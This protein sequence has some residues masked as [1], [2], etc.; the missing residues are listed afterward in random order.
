MTPQTLSKSFPSLATLF[1]RSL[2]KGE[3]RLPSSTIVDRL[4]ERL[5]FWSSPEI[6]PF[7]DW[8]LSTD[9]PYILLDAVFDRLLHFTGLRRLH[10]H[11]VHFTQTKVDIL[12]HL[13]ILTELD[14]FLGSVAP[15]NPI[16]SLPQ[17]L[18][19]SDFAVFYPRSTQ[20]ENIPWIPL[21][22]PEN[23]HSLRADLSPRLLGAAVEAIPSFTNVHTLEIPLPASGQNLSILAKFPA[24]RVLKVNAKKNGPSVGSHPRAPPTFPLLREYTGPYQL[25]PILI[26]VATL[27]HLRVSNCSHKDFITML[28]AIGR[29]NSITSF[30][31]EFSQ[32]TTAAFLA[33]LELLPRLA[34]LAI[35]TVFDSIHSMFLRESYD[36]LKLKDDEIVDG[37][38]A[39]P[40]TFFLALPTFSTLPPNLERLAISWECYDL[41]MDELV[42]YRLPKFEQLRD[43]LLIKCPRLTWLY[44][45]GYYFMHQWRT[46]P[47]GVA[48]EETATN[49]LDAYGQRQGAETFCKWWEWS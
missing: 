8:I 6:A 37:R 18:R 47:E 28:R 2:Y 32:F 13:P 46:T 12:C 22:H 26:P 14:I 48:K 45:D 5:D 39:P 44:V 35:R 40:S 7:T 19:V 43:A 15:G 42:A 27:T 29:P 31:A 9:S 36:D 33:L 20:P 24:V 4:L 34:E 10:T 1:V 49:F 41:H 16:D 21:L 11:N 17:A 38:H 23:L 30:H 25:L 3:L